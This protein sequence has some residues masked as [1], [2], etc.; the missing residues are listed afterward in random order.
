MGFDC[1]DSGV[2]DYR[3]KGA[4]FIAHHEVEWRL[5][6]DGVRAVIVS[7]F[8]VGDV[9]GPR[10]G[11]VSAEDPKVRFDFLVYSFGFSIRLGMVGGRKG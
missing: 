10:S 2:R 3:G 4:G 1:R 8:G 9:I 11:V 7:E 6:G 5:I